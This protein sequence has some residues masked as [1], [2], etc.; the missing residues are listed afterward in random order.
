MEKQKQLYSMVQTGSVHKL[1]MSLT[2]MPSSAAQKKNQYNCSATYWPYLVIA[3][4]ALVH[5]VVQVHQEISVGEQILVPGH[6]LTDQLVG[7]QLASLVLR[8]QH[9]GLW[10]EDRR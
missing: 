9:G 10:S 4:E 8:W 7:L 2:C 5:D 6:H 3:G 1:E